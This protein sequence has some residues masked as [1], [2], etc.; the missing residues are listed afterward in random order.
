[1]A[2]QYQINVVEKGIDKYIKVAVLAD[3]TDSINLILS[4]FLNV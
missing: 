3:D 1:M 4:Q 2:K